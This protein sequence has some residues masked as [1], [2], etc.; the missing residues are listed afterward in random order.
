MIHIHKHKYNKIHNINELNEYIIDIVVL[1][2][3][4][5]CNIG[6]IAMLPIE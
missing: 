1:Y 4:I 5:D 2:N 6:C 3:E